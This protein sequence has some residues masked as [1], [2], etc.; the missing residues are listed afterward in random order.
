MR[1]L[2]IEDDKKVASFILKGLTESG[3]AVDVSHDGSKG[4]ILAE[5]EP[6]DLVIIDWMLPGKDGLGVCKS[7]R[8]SKPDLPILFLTAKDDISDKVTGL[9]AGADDYLTKPFSF[10]ELLARIRTLMRRGTRLTEVLAVDDLE[11][12][13]G[14][15]KV[16]RGGQFIDLSNKEFA[17]LEFL[18]RNKN[19]LITRTEMTEHVWNIQFDRG[20]NLIDVYINY[21]RKKLDTGTKK[22]LIHTVRGAGYTIKDTV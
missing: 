17:I 15:R 22:P 19:R 10:L 11:M 2:L 5:E 7:L 6:Y 1:I 13:L 20:T 21:L 9:D 18:L 14:E 12:N 16:Y 8:M 4:L 3:Y